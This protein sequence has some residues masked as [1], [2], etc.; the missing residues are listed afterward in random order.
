MDLAVMISHRNLVFSALDTVIVNEE[1]VNVYPVRCSYLLQKCKDNLQIASCPENPCPFGSLT[2]VS[3]NGRTFLLVPAICQ[4]LHI[5]R[6][7]PL[8]C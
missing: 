4:P 2:L 8:E 7:P 3:F 6:T 1:T 5:S